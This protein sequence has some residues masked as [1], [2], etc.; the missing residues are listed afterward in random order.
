MGTILMLAIVVV[1][2]AVIG[3]FVL[4]FGDQTEGSPPDA[5]LVCTDNGI[6]HVAGDPVPAE[7]VEGIDASQVDG[8]ALSAGET[9]NA[10]QLVWKEGDTGSVLVECEGSGTTGPGVTLNAQVGAVSPPYVAPAS[11]NMPGRLQVTV[12]DKDGNPYDP[13]GG[14]DIEVVQNPGNKFSLVR[15]GHPNQ[16]GT[17]KGDSMT[18]LSTTNGKLPTG[19]SSAHW[20]DFEGNLDRNSEYRVE[21]SVSGANGNTVT[22]SFLVEVADYNITTV[23]YDGVEDNSGTSGDDSVQFDATIKNVNDGSEQ[24]TVKTLLFENPSGQLAPSAADAKAQ[25]TISVNEGS[26][27]TLSEADFPGL[28]TSDQVVDGSSDNAYALMIIVEGVP[29][30]VFELCSFDTSVPMPTC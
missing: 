26:K 29:N 28:I 11:G 3:G 9:V 21:A 16:G 27:K 5:R 12:Q 18:G 15:G 4:G 20:I 19:F 8:E 14:V 17:D 24:T 30:N 13:P 7:T 2:A 23:T 22:D 10:Q 25:K 6:E 1:I